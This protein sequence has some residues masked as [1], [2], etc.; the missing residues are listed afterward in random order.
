VF[1]GFIAFWMLSRIGDFL[2]AGVSSTTSPRPAAVPTGARTPI[3]SLTRTP[4]PIGQIDFGTRAGANCTVSDLRST[5]AAGS[6]VWWSARF[7]TQLE[8]HEQVRWMVLLDGRVLERSVGPSDRPS[9]RWDV[10]CSDDPLTY[11]VPGIYWLRFV[12]TGTGDLL[13]ESTFTVE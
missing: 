12:H 7:R 9:G 5:F 10:L 3:P 6:E 1:I 8:P 13:A 11:D 4:V 2:P